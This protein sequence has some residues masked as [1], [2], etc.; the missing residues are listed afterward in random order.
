MSKLKTEGASPK[1]ATHSKSSSSITYSQSNKVLLKNLE[2]L[3]S[4]KDH[5][6]KS[7]QLTLEISNHSRTPS[8]FE[9]YLRNQPYSTNNPNLLKK[10][11]H[12]NKL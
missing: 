11:V 6:V 8:N 1:R 4:K 12:K 10:F 9:S 3:R 5:H 2:F 7:R